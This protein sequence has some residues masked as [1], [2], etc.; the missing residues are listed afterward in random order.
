MV[1]SNGDLKMS[2]ASNTTSPKTRE[3][4]SIKEFVDVNGALCDDIEKAAGL[5]YTALPD[6]KQ[7]VL[8]LSTEASEVGSPKLMFALFG[9]TTRCTIIAT[10]NRKKAIRDRFSSDADA[11]QSMFTNTRTGVWGGAAKGADIDVL[12][13]ALVEANGGKEPPMG[14]AAWKAKVTAAPELA[15]GFIGH[16][17]IGAIY[18]RMLREKM[19]AGEA[20]EQSVEDLLAGMTA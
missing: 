1:P 19:G 11:V 6:K 8:M 7:T 3:D 17:S 14:E 16:K 20:S 13:L 2:D 18:E 10:Q 9:L 4:V 12:W 5:R 15:E